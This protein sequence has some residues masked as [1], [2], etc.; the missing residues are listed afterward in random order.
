MPFDPSTIECVGDLASL[1]RGNTYKS[2]LLGFPG[3][4][5][6]GLA[7]I[8]RGGGFRSDNLK[9]YGGDC[10][11]KLLLN[12]G[13]LY[14]SLKDVTQAAD[15]LGAVARVPVGVHGRLTQDTVKLVMPGIPDAWKAYLY[16]LLRAP[17]YRAYCK[18]NSMGT[19]NLSL[20]RED[21]LEYPVP[22]LSA[23]RQHIVA[24]L[25]NIEARIDHNRALAANLEAIARA[26]FKSWFVDFDPV[27]AKAAGE[28]PPGLAPDLAAL[29]P[30]RFVDSELGEIPEGWAC[31]PITKI[32]AVHS[33]GTP[34]RAVDEY[35]GGTIPWYSVVDA[36]RLGEVFVIETSEHITE[37]G[38]T[39]SAA[40]A[41]PHGVTII[42][43]RGTV[44]KLAL[45]CG[46]MTI[47]QS[48]YA[49]KGTLGDF[50]TYFT[51]AASI[52]WLKQ[53]VH[54]AVFDTITRA[55]LDGLLVIRPSDQAARAF[56]DTVRPIMLRIEACSR[57]ARVL[58]K[59]RDL[60]LP[61]LISG[62]LRVEDAEAAMEAA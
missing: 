37:A 51:I 55:T 26:L 53:N 49:L 35:W 36:P 12:P 56:E 41:L 54:G 57:E 5:L 14:V 43:A 20:S 18:A 50:F 16:W 59:L 42:S 22:P 58:A 4:T 45:T 9:T 29:F 48:C 44:G 62:K 52:D 46:P 27:R 33:G 1:Q 8:A 34:K 19:T 31:S 38:S 60:L 6:L 15:L 2:A 40:K 10:P 47:N 21:F 28:A 17:E 11:E 3:P 39:N 7:S 32:A 24:A 23:S 30:D 13:D 61:R 25:E